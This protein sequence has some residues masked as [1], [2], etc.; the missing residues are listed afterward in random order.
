MKELDSK[1]I[2]KV[3]SGGHFYLA[4]SAN[5]QLFGWGTTKYNRFG[6]SGDD[7]SI[8]KQIPIKI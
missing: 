6:V 1:Q 3:C 8:P 2:V 7:L 4:L 5:G